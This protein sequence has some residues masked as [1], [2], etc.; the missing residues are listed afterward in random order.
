MY[1]KE[2]WIKNYL[3]YTL[4]PVDDWQPFTIGMYAYK[5]RELQ[6]IDSVNKE[7]IAYSDY[8]QLHLTEAHH[9]V[10]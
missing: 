8:A 1:Y 7:D 2:K 5:L 9:S 3:Y 4:S 6:E 10:D